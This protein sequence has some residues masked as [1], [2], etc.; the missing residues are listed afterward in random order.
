MVV[1]M[2]ELVLTLL[3]PDQFQRPVGDHLVR[4]HVS[5]S[6]RPALNHVHDE[7]IMRF[8][9]GEFVATLAD[10]PGTFAVENPEFGVGQG[11]RFLYARKGANEMFIVTNADAGERKV[12]FGPHRLH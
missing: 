7:L 12:F 4:A 10:R 6:S 2:A 5:R 1:W 11:R 3:M 8:A 9:R